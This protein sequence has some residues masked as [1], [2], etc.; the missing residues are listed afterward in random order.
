MLTRES[1]VEDIMALPG[2]IAWCIRHGVSPFSC[3]GAFPGTL[4]RLLEIKGV[5]DVDGFIQAMN[6]ELPKHRPEQP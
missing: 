1:Q 4:G 5:Q 6:T 2:L 3:Y